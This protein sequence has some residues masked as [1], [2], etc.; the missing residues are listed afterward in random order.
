MTL[1]VVLPTYNER[2]ELERVA[3]GDP[4][5]I[6]GRGCSSSTTNHRTARGSWPTIWR[7]RSG[8]RRGHASHGPAR[9]RSVRT[10]MACGARSRR[11]P[12]RSARWTPT[13][14]TIRSTCPISSRRSSGSISSI[15]SRYL[16]GVSVVNWPLHRDHAERVRESLHPLHHRPAAHDC[17]SGFR[18][19][20]REAL[21]KLPLD[22]PQANGYAFLTE[23]LF[24]AARAGCRIG[25][26]P[27]VFVERSEGYSKVSRQ[28]AARVAA[29]ALAPHAAR[30]AA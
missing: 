3:A 19:W 13:S 23:M 17:T 4:P 29:D 18:V 1:L 5:R 2:L 16:H 10:S 20:R 9:P 6:R 26:V 28:R 7:R 15:G 25:E 30:R 21:A 24:E 8:P 14:R 11:T 12:T 27:I 22:T